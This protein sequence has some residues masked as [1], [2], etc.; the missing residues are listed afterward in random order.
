MSP[1]LKYT[2]ELEYEEEPDYNRL[3]YMFK[4]ILL[5]QDFVPDSRFD[6]SLGAGENYKRLENQTNHSSISSCGIKSGE[7]PCSEDG[8]NHEK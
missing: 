6:W 8:N 2:Y 7:A 4:K 5:D 3:R 1:I